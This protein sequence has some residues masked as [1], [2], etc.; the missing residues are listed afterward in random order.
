[1]KRTVL[2]LGILIVLC[3]T[4]ALFGCESCVPKGSKDPNGNGPYSGAICWT[5]ASGEW[6]WCYGGNTNCTG[7]T[8]GS[9]GGGQCVEPGLAG[10]CVLHP[11]SFDGP[12][13]QVKTCAVDASGACSSR[14]IARP[15]VLR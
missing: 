6:S 5:S 10:S 11:M 4:P 9:C 2:V 12:A 13:G 7:D 1:M 8:D 15:S 3:S 14:A